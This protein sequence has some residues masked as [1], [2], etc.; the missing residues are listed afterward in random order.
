[1]E[2]NRKRSL[3][4]WRISIICLIW[5]IFLLPSLAT[6]GETYKFERMWP[7]LQQPW[8]FITPSDVEVDK[9]NSVVY[10]VDMN[11][12]YIYK[13]TLDGHFVTRWGGTEG[14]G[15]GEFKRPRKITVDHNGYVYVAD[16]ANHNI[17]KFTSDGEF[18][19]KWGGSGESSDDGEF[20]SPKGIAADSN[21]FIYIADS[22]N[23]RIQKFTSNGEL[24]KKW[25]KLGDGDGEF[26]EPFGIAVDNKDNVY[27]ADADNHNIQ[28]F[29]SDG[30]FLIKWGNYG[31]GDGQFNEPS[32]IA[33]D[34]NGYICVADSTNNRIQKFTSDGEFAGKWG[35]YG[36]GDGE[37]IKPTGLA[38]DDS[39]FVYVAD[40][41][42][43][44]IQKFNLKGSF[45]KKWGCVG[46]GY[47]EF[48]GP[49]GIG[50]DSNDFIYVADTL[51]H[52]VQKFNSNG[53]FNK[54]WGNEGTGD[55]EFIYPTG[56]AIDSNNYVY[57]S[58]SENHR[59]QKFNSEG[60]LIA[61][62]GTMGSEDGQFQRPTG[63]TVDNN[64]FIYVAD[65]FNNRIQKF[66]PKGEFV[67]KWESPGYLSGKLIYPTHVAVDSKGFVYVPYILTHSIQKFT[68][69]GAFFNEFKVYK[70]NQAII[71]LAIDSEDFV[72]VASSDT[73]FIEKYTSEGERI[74]AFGG[75][76]LGAG[77]LSYPGDLFISKSGK[78]YISDT[79]NHRVQVFRKGLDTERK[80]KAIIV[81]GGWVGDSLWDAIQMN[82]NFAYYVLTYQGFSDETIYYLNSKTDLYTVDDY[83]T[84][85]KLKNIIQSE[86]AKDTDDLILYLV[87]HGDKD[88]FNINKTENL[89]ASELNSWL[90]S[91]QK[92]IPGKLIVIY[93]ACESGTF[94]D[95]LKP[96]ENEKRIVITSTSPDEKAWFITQ[97]A[98]SF[99][100][101]FWTHIFNGL[102]IKHAFDLAD[103]AVGYIN[104]TENQNP[105]IDDNGDAQNTYIGP[106]AGAS[107]VPE[108]E[109]V[110]PDQTISEG[111]S[112]DLY[113]SGVTDD[114][115]IEYVRAVI[116]PPDFNSGASNN[117]LQD[118]PS[119]E[120]IYNEQNNRY[121]ATYEEFNTEGTY[122]ILIYAMD[123]KGNKSIPI[124]TNVNIKSPLT[125]KAIIVA[126][127][128]DSDFPKPATENNAKLAYNAL[129]TQGYSEDDIYLMSSNE[130]SIPEVPKMPVKST[131]DNLEYA[132]STWS[133]NN[134][135][136]LVIYMLGSGDNEKFHVNPTESLSAGKLD[137]WLDALQEQLPGIIV[138]IYDASF[139][140]SFISLLMPSDEKERIVITSTDKDQKVN[141][142]ADGDISF[143]QYFWN[144]VWNGAN[145]R[146]C[147]S[148]AKKV[149]TDLEELLEKAQLPH[150]ND[151]GNGIGNEGYDSNPTGNEGR[152]G[153]LANT[154]NIGIGLG[155]AYRPLIR[156]ISPTQVLNGVKSVTIW[157]NDV[158]LRDS[159]TNKIQAI[160]S[161]P[162]RE[163]YSTIELVYN[164]DTGRYEGIYD[165]FTD[166]GKYDIIVYAKNSEGNVSLPI[167]TRFYQEISGDIDG[168]HNADLTD[169]LLVLKILAGINV[170]PRED[171]STSGVDVNG[172]NK[173]GMEEVVYILQNVAGMK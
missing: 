115:G 62:W 119:T 154:Y 131:L 6:S 47:G 2:S 160:I 117:P 66:D 50:V 45:V 126:G 72:Y 103:K 77:Q 92:D 158:S 14:N 43:F 53:E 75:S 74:T 52:R 90:D 41:N 125:R 113:A 25:G 55:K 173:V 24:V 49:V 111:N 127:K 89:L 32:G 15:D 60:S 128:P 140:G 42:N 136:D 112:A 65:S 34:N 46:S 97:G 120:L 28:K 151:N 108:I 82:A 31:S 39:G 110:S 68:P 139:S 84:N 57:V 56:L 76:G 38:F 17:Q 102:S 163:S 101:Y 104:T 96:S 88:I 167:T 118:L 152:D 153:N 44:R 21:G 83:A 69:N 99:S 106:G 121:E 135:R 123:R 166:Y 165:G 59:I 51:N 150:L 143:S 159:A 8:Y 37:L 93:D 13:F 35:E 33:V 54:T 129:I 78:V 162:N 98:I 109:N 63:I 91:L 61:K 1:M 171:Y 23:H 155:S 29:T 107:D 86:W 81:A 9:R 170:E 100:N 105:L 122:Q 144:D 94:L 12:R 19:A 138:L 26:N 157:A 116:R 27:V 10:V 70:A 4:L 20:F 30:E 172:D 147:F 161:P 71:S 141:S 3:G 48:K 67:F 164:S 22:H 137:E 87:D 149:F 132:V 130:A 169:A 168:D 142:V 36:A 95:S 156:N 80:M 7:T 16:S 18:L 79:A 11:S 133:A 85:E 146:L 73:S 124:L 40:S 64:N 114:D 145:V 58:D 134:T 148:N 5:V